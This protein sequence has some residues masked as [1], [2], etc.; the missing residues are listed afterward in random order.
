MLFLSTARKIFDH[1]EDVFWSK[2]T[3]LL[4]DVPGHD[5]ELNSLEKVF[6]FDSWNKRPGKIYFTIVKKNAKF[7]LKFVN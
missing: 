2:S 5:V 6:G 7:T 4:A 1:L 3:Y